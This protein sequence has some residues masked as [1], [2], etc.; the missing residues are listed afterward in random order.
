MGKTVCPCPTELTYPSG[1]LTAIVW[2][3]LLGSFILAYLYAN[4][5]P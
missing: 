1:E 5:N 3:I 4:R 2:V